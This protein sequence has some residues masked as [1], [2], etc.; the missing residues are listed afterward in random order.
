MTHRKESTSRD[1]RLWA[2]GEKNRPLR[3]QTPCECGCDT[4][5]G[6]HRATQAY[7]TWSDAHGRGVSIWC[8]TLTDAKRLKERLVA[9]RRRRP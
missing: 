2:G 3:V 1:V 9:L 5:D 8:A 7:V 4:R 6:M